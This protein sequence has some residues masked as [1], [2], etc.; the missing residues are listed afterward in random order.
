MAIALGLGLAA[1]GDDDGGDAAADSE[2]GNG[3]DTY[4]VD[5]LSYSDVSAPAGGTIEIENTSGLP[6]TF[7][8]DDTS[9]DEDYAADETITVTV[10]EEPGEY[11]FHCEIHPQMEAT[12][13][14]E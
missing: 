1:C 13:T 4:V 7:T 5:D 2:S 9:F 10:P 14:V 8:A 11:P 6:H 12:L 3:G